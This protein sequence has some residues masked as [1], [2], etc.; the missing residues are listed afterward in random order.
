[1]RPR[2]AV[3]SA[4]P[5]GRARA[6]SLARFRRTGLKP[7]CLGLGPGVGA[8]GPSGPPC[9]PLALCWSGPVRQ[10]PCPRAGRW[11][12]FLGVSFLIA[13]CA[14]V[15]VCRQGS[16]GGAGTVA[17]LVLTPVSSCHPAGSGPRTSVR[18]FSASLEVRFFFKLKTRGRPILDPAHF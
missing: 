15:S 11:R 2:E 3:S 10:T 14:A 4:V 18:C 1:M 7:A 13:P 5:D 12:S 6:A 17:G 9:P 16:N 8:A